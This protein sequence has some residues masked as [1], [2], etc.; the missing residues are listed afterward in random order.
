MMAVLGITMPDFVSDIL[1]TGFMRFESPTGISGLAK[2]DDTRLDILAVDAT[3]PG[4][5]QFREFIKQCKSEYE[6]IYIWEVWSPIMHS[7]L[8]RYGFHQ[9]KEFQIDADVEG[10]RWTKERE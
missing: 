6:S 9:I 3:T 8:E 7:A 1:G 10:W 2:T 4:F 5:G